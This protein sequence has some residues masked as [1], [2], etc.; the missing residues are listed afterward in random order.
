MDPSTDL[1]QRLL[2]RPEQEWEQALAET[3]AAHPEHAPDVRRKCAR[4]GTDAMV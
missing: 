4:T 3:C 2:Q 1:L